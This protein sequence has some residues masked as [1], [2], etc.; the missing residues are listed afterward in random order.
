LTNLI[1]AFLQ[2]KS[3]RTPVAQKYRET[4][5]FSQKVVQF[6][7]LPPDN[8]LLQPP[9]FPTGKNNQTVLLQVHQLPGTVLQL[10]QTYL[11]DLSLKHRILNPVQV[12]PT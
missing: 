2:N 9:L 11:R 7:L 1:F 4:D 8:F 5:D 12:T 6:I 3:R 10:P